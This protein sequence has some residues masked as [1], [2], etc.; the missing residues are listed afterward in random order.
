MSMFPRNWTMSMAHTWLDDPN[1]GFYT[2]V[3]LSC[4][5]KKFWPAPSK[6][7]PNSAEYNFAV[8]PDANWYMLRGLYRHTVDALANKFTLAHLKKYNI[9]MGVPVAPE[10]RRMNFAPH[11]DQYSNFN[12]GK[13]LLIIEG[14]GGLRYS[15]V[16]D[17][18]TF[19]D[20][21]PTNWT[22]MEFQVP[23]QKPGAEVTWVKARAERKNN[24][25]TVVKTVT[26]EGNPFKNL[27]VQPW[28]DDVKVSAS[29]PAGGKLD[30]PE[31]H[32]G[33]LFNAPS[34]TVTLTL[35]TSVSPG[36]DVGEL[37]W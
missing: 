30:Q 22:Y 27:V 5:A 4:T 2:D 17:T 19:A 21:L 6:V 28:A 37:G 34:A 9:E 29:S 15:A 1:N 36:V 18:F 35:D 13:I 8:T 20:N 33:W 12:A 26:V 31:G 7:D 32:V 24:G 3:P 16:E 10:T 25:N 11:G 14:I 23:V